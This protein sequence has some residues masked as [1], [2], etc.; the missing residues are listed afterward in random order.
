MAS[1]LRVIRRSSP[2]PVIVRVPSFARGSRGRAMAR[3]GLS[4]AA[5]QAASERQALTGIIAAG[6]LGF[7]ARQG[8]AL[9]HVQA[10]GTAGTVGAIAWIIGKVTKQ[11]MFRDAAAGLLS[12][13]A[14]QHAKGGSAV[15]GLSEDD[16]EAA[17]SGH[18]G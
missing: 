14:Y 1:A 13:A 16:V 2:K 9:P 12:V 15:E 18:M 17:I 11:R 8:V 5:R 10:L 7:L 6:G 4:I 3:R